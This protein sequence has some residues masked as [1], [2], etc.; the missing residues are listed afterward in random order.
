MV[1]SRPQAFGL[2]S[3]SAFGPR[4]HCLRQG[5]GPRP[6]FSSCMFTALRPFGPLARSF[7]PKGLGVAFYLGWFAQLPGSAL[8]AWKLRCPDVGPSGL[9]ASG[10]MLRNF[11]A[12]R[13][14]DGSYGP[15]WPGSAAS[16]LATSGVLSSG[17]GGPSAASCAS[18]LAPQGPMVQQLGPAMRLRLTGLSAGGPPEAPAGS[19]LR[20][21]LKGTFRAF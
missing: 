18:K 17:G 16:C 11:V 12:P 9:W 20:G 1:E 14:P 7:G 21:A 4:P 8:R 15:Q 13:G 6:P 3:R 19:P 2:S 5:Q 10:S